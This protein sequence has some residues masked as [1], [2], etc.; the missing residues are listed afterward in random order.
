M[1]ERIELY[2]PIAE[3][4]AQVCRIFD[5][6]LCSEE[7]FVRE[8]CAH[9][10]RYRGKMVRPALV[11]L[12]AD[13]CGRVTNEHLILAAVVEMVHMAT[14]VHDDVLD[15]SEM[16][17]RVPT[18]NCLHGN[19]AAVLLGDLLISHAFHLCS[20]LD[21]TYASRLIGSTTNTVCEGELMQVRHR[22]NAG[23]TQDEYFAII[24]RKTAGLMSTCCVLGA[25]YAGASPAR[26]ARMEN[27]GL[28][29][30]MAFQIVDDVLDIVGS[31]REMG[32]TLGRDLDKAELT[33]PLIH[34]LANAPDA[35]RA[36]AA[37]AL[38][39]GNPARASI[40]RELVAGTTSIEYA[41]GVAEQYVR[42]ALGNLAELPDTPAR[43]SLETMARFILRRHH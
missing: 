20:S 21:S 17:R 27:Y 11:L 38:K 40:L 39:N 43:R 23:L 29:V 30:G 13:A 4:L 25:R 42:S 34:F 32:K 15:D 31:Q 22:G 24:S 9:I 41:V 5:D 18:I 33:L 7:A 1:I 16:R 36:K 10:A 12:S 8:L 2:E 35:E 14:L 37:E 3:P 28:D 26:I 6:E 19:E